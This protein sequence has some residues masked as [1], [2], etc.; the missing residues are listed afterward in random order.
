VVL[1]A[2]KAWE[3]VQ[4]RRTQAAERAGKREHD[5]HRECRE[6]VAELRSEVTTLRVSVVACET[7]HDAAQREVGTLRSLVEYLGERLTRVERDS[8]RP[9]VEPAE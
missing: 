8:Q 6:E 7:K 9:T 2:V 4:A 5:D 3:R 1:A